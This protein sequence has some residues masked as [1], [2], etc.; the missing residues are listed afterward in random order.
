MDPQIL[1]ALRSQFVDVLCNFL[2]IKL[3]V[4]SVSYHLYHLSS[5]LVDG[6]NIP[7]L[8]REVG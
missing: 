2:L 1:E 3:H 5:L 6:E 8:C 7:A 4:F